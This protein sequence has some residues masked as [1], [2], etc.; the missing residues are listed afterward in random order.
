MSDTTIGTH[1]SAKRKAISN[2][3]ILL[4]ITISL[5]LILY[6]FSVIMFQDNNF[7][8]FSIFFNTFFNEKPYLLAL[9]LGLTVVLIAGSIDISVGGVTGL[10][11]M[12]TAVMLTEHGI[13]A[14]WTIPTAVG[15]G[16]A[17][18]VVQGFLVAYMQIQPFIVTLAGMF[19][20][21]GMISVIRPV[22]VPINDPLFLSWSSAKLYI[23]FLYNVRRNGTH[24]VAYLVPAGIVVLIALVIIVIL[25]KYTRFGR[26]VY[27]VG[28][29]MQSALLMGI[30]P[31]RIKFHAH[32]ICGL[33]S[34]IGGFVF[35]LGMPSGS[36]D[37][38]RGYEIHAISSSII[39]G[40]MFSGG[41]GL[42]MGTFFGVLIN[43]L[44]Q[45]VVPL[46]GLLEA[47]WPT[48]ITSAFLFAFIVLQS[49]L[50]LAS[51]TDGGLRRLIPAWLRFSIP[52]GNKKK[53]NQE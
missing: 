37:Y 53:A 40:T 1:L 51:K 39:G 43:L 42:P 14:M 33:L 20:A 10:V 17:F 31:K 3:G 15:I 22:S 4:I 26:S 28:G 35:T 6:I 27:A 12:V 18:G 19:F 8:K 45:R 24:D 38:G 41:V 48:I 25:L 50:S 13:N 32:V 44:V 47:S 36:P 52:S 23:P 2:T 34:G 21:R 16:L 29:N 9:S 7:G 49:V 11:A 30:D 46:F 5:F